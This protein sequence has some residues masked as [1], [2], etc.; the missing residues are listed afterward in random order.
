MKVYIPTPLR[1]YTRK[2]AVIEA[3]GETVGELLAEMNR[4]YPGVRFRIVDEQDGIRRHI[5]I[6]VNDEQVPDL[7]T[8]VRPADTVHIVCA[9]SGGVG[10]PPR[11]HRT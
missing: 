3:K 7:G 5:K 4:H 11:H 1:S 2:K 10:F 9:L 6:F 8:P